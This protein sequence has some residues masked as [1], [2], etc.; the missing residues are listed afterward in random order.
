[1][2]HITAASELPELLQ[3]GRELGHNFWT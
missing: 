1:M 3:F 2:S